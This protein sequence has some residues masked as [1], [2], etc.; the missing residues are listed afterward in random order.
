MVSDFYLVCDKLFKNE[1]V[2]ELVILG[3]SRRDVL[4]CLFLS[5]RTTPEFRLLFDP[6]DCGQDRFNV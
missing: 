3:V 5:E 2:P 6:G 4:A 1:R